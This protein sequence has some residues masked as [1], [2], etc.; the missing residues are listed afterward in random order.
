MWKNSPL[1]F[2]AIGLFVGL[3]GCDQQLANRIERDITNL[4][5]DPLGVQPYP[6]IIGGNDAD[7]FYATNLGDIP[8]NI[9]GSKNDFVI[10]GLLGPSNVYEF[11]KSKP[12]LIRPL[13]PSAF[14][15]LRRMTTDGR[16]LVYTNAEIID[17]QLRSNT[18]IVEDL[19]LAG[20]VNPQVVYRIDDASQQFVFPDLLLDSG[21]LVVTTVDP[22]TGI[23]SFHIIDLLTESAETEFEAGAH[24]YAANLRGGL[25]AYIADVNNSP[26][27]MLR[28]LPTGETTVL[29]DEVILDYASI[30]DIYLSLNG[31]VWSEYSAP[32]LIRIVRYDTTTGQTRVWADAV[33]GR[34]AGATDEFLLTEEQIIRDEPFTSGDKADLVRIRRID[35]DGKVKQ[36]AEFRFDGLAGQS[37]VIGNRAVWVNAERKV[38]I[39]PFDNRD[40]NSFKPF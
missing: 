16:F 20:I 8:F 15:F 25:L 26:V 10:P 12:D 40:R 32:N 5:E 27:A 21:R 18:V 1:K 35:I 14:P 22:A 7:V 23:S 13:G 31:I 19:F 11:S 37:R 6:V 33:E 38:V 29:S 3:L 30:P 24:I 39:A 28:D 9:P 4:I 17:E 34:L 36:L 2:L